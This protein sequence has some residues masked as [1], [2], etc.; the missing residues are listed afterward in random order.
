MEKP[1]DILVRGRGSQEMIVSQHKG[2]GEG[3]GEI[4]VILNIYF[5]WLPLRTRRKGDDVKRL[6]DLKK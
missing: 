6:D 2:P 1:Y 4:E 3:D 5:K